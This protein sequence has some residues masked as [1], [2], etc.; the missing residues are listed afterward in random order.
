MLELALEFELLL[1]AQ[2]V[3]F[4]EAL[5]GG[6][7]Q[8]VFTN[9]PGSFAGLAQEL[10]VWAEEVM[11]EA[12]GAVELVDE[13]HQLGS[14]QPLV[15]QQLAHVRPVLLLAMGVVVFAVGAAAGE[16]H[17][18][19]SPGEVFVQGPVEELAAVVAVEADHAE[20]H[21]SFECPDLGEDSV[22]GL[23]PEGAVLGP[24]AAELCKR[25]GI[26]VIPGGGV[27]TMGDRVHLDVAQLRRVGRAGT[28]GDVLA[29][30]R[31]GPG[32]GEAFL[33]LA[34]AYRTEE[35]VDLRG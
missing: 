1:L 27:V 9:G 33:G 34:D 18:R 4:Q 28:G 21:G 3:G 14:L 15:A 32:G 30:E 22:A 10:E 26:D 31:A 2:M 11:Q 20:G 19:A 8:A 25:E 5:V 35:A 24:P 16:G 17:L 6:L 12:P 29:Q 7:R 13:G 23:V